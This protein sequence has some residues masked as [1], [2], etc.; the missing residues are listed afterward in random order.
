MVEVFSM[1]VS[2]DALVFGFPG[3]SVGRVSEFV[4]IPE[5]D[6]DVDGTELVSADHKRADCR[7]GLHQATSGSLSIGQVSDDWAWDYRGCVAY[8]ITLDVDEI[9]GMVRSARSYFPTYSTLSTC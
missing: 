9:G 8:C 6:L 1:C 5:V 7:Y 3:R 4:R 2:C